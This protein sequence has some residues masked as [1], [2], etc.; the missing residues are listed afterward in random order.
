[1]DEMLKATT[2]RCDIQTKP[3]LVPS[4]VIVM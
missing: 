1:V 2:G 4:D 3:D